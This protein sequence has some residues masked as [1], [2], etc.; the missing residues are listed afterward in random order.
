[1]DRDLNFSGIIVPMSYRSMM[2]FA[3]GWIAAWNRRDVDS[4]LGHFADDAEFISPLAQKY[5]GSSSLIGK[6]ALAPYWRTALENITALEFTLTRFGTRMRA[7]CW[8]CT[9]QISTESASALA[10]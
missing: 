1:M 5:S 4:V 8:S 2:E 7:N 3:E 10:N 9:K 6:A